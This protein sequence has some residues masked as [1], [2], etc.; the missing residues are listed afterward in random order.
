MYSAIILSTSSAAKCLRRSSLSRCQKSGLDP[1]LLEVVDEDGD[2]EVDGA[3]EVEADEAVAGLLTKR[4]TFA[5]E[6][7]I[8]Q[9][10]EN[11]RMS[12]R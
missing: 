2:V 11:R 8:R 6:E 3:V 5:P 12:F 1:D 7:N 4:W 9:K 10:E